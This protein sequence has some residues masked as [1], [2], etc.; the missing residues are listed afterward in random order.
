MRE[1]GKSEVA[2]M[3]NHAGAIGL[4]C[5]LSTNLRPSLE[6]DDQL[7]SIERCVRD[8]A[9]VTGGSVRRIL[10]RIEYSPPALQPTAP[11]L[12]STPKGAE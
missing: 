6:R 1:R 8:F 11:I 4:L 12:Q 9:A 2:R 10:Q 3:L 5:E 7:D